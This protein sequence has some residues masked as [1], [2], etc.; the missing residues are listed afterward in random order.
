VFKEAP[1]TDWMEKI[2]KQNAALDRF[3]EKLDE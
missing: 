1:V 3:E 2:D